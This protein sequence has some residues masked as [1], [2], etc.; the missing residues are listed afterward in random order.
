[1][2]NNI[3]LLAIAGVLVS[4]TTVKQNPSVYI[5][6]SALKQSVN[7]L[8]RVDSCGHLYKMDYS[9]DYNLDRV[10]SAG[11]SDFSQLSQFVCDSILDGATSPAIDAGTGCSSFRAFTPDKEALFARNYD[12]HHDQ[13][14][15]V[16]F[17]TNAPGAYSSLCVADVSWLG[18]KPG[19]LDDGVTDVSM[20]SALPYIT[21]DGMNEK[22][23]ALSMM[24]LHGFTTCQNEDGKTIMNTTVAVRLAL[25]KA[26]CVDDVINLWKSHNMHSEIP[27]TDFQF[28]VA[29]STGRAVVLSYFNGELYVLDEHRVSNTHL[30]PLAGRDPSDCHRYNIMRETL[31]FARDT[32]TVQDAMN[33]LSL[34][35]QG[36][37]PNSAR[38]QWSSVYN[39][40]SLNLTLCVNRD[41]K[42]PYQF[43][44]N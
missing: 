29:D 39:L 41:Y 20:L 31:E 27:G 25:D 7:T 24:Q 33:I 4:C 15:A 12:F 43:S 35:R 21:I 42:H 6:D 32:V 28:L 18:F 22:G 44:L 26:S 10:L 30:N 11:I 3:L 2:K 9:Y 14:V 19:S 8:S 5:K 13:P 16:V 1:M 36:E 38:T 37:R 23:V 40:N 17:H 34:I